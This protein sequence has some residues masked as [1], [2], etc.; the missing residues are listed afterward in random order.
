MPPSSLVLSALAGCGFEREPPFAGAR[1][2]DV[3]A[4]AATSA[5]SRSA[6]APRTSVAPAL[7]APACARR[8]G[9]AAPPAPATAT[10]RSRE[11]CLCGTLQ[12]RRLRQRRRVRPADGRFVCTFADRRC[13][14]ACDADGDCAAGE[15]CVPGRHVCR[16]TCTDDRRLPARRAL[17]HRGSGLCV[18][19]R[20]RRRRRLRR[21]RL[22]AAA[23]RRARRRAVA[24]RRHGRRRHALLRA[25]RRR[26]RRPPSGAPPATAL[27]LTVDAHALAR[28]ARRRSRASAT[29]ATPWSS[30]AR[31]P[32][33]TLLRDRARPTAS[34]GHA[35]RRAG[36]RPAPASPSLIVAVD[37]TP[38]LCALDAAG[39]LA[40]FTGTRRSRLRHA[41]R[42]AHAG[43][44]A[45]AAVARRRHA[46]H[47]R[48]PSATST[49][50][51]R[52]AC[53]CGSPRTAPRAAPRRSSARPRRHRPTGRSASPSP[54]TTPPSRPTPY[55]PVFDR[56]SDFINHP[57]EL[58]PAVV[59]LRRHAG[60]STTAAPTPT[61]ATPRRSPSPARRCSPATRNI[62]L[63]SVATM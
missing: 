45:H 40:R 53:A 31:P 20:L 19:D 25:H 8:D 59:A 9:A 42:R 5:R 28:L 13:D 44:R 27:T 11:R 47:A 63:P 1:I 34:P 60:C 52:R 33:P 51:A 43:R 30:R 15:R 22:R 3:G 16:G 38:L 50:T 23:H 12:R 49:P 61:A 41:A 10:A 18:T 6:T 55:D 32:A 36:A 7:G 29:A 35:P 37:G 46:R 58:D 24:A 54:P 57:G 26:R 56:T 62:Y 14:R 39:N 48:S 4:V 2:A 21:P 17:R